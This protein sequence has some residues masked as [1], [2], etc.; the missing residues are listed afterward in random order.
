[1]A[2]EDLVDRFGWQIEDREEVLASCM[3]AKGATRAQRLAEFQEFWETWIG[4]VESI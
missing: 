2:V 4:E 1:M 3:D